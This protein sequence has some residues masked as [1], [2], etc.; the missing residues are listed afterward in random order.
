MC[1]IAGHWAHANGQADAEAVRRMMSA[2]G[3]RGPDGQ[4]LV[5]SGP[6]A[7]GHRRLSIIDLSGG[8]QPLTNEDGSVTVVFNGEIYNYRELAAGLRGKHELRTL[9]D[10]EVLVHL[11]EECGDDMVLELRG[12]FAFALW[13]S[14][15]RRLLAARDRLGKKPLLYADTGKA[16][17]FASELRAFEAAGAPL[18][19]IDRAALSEYL[20]LLYVPA[21][22]TIW[23]GVKKLPAGHLL[24]ADAGGV[25]VRRYWSPPVPGSR[26]MDRSDVVSMLEK[27]LADSVR[28]RLRSDV[29]VGVL[30]SGG[31]D[32]SVV[33]A[34][35]ARTFAGPLRTF[36]VGFGR[37]DDEL[38]IARA[39]AAHC[40]TEHR[41]IVLSQDVA[42]ATERALAGFSE[43]F[44]DSSAVPCS[45]VFREV[46][47]H[48]KVVLTGDGGDELF[49]GYGRYRTVARLP[50]VPGIGR[51]DMLP[52]WVPAHPRLQSLGRGAR[53][54]GARGAR[55]NRAMVEV[56]GPAARG[57]L[58]GGFEHAAPVVERVST[59]VEAALDADLCGYLPDD[60]LVKTD[61][62][63]MMWSVEARCPL[64]DQEL[65][66]AIVPLDSALKQNGTNGKLVL[67]DLAEKLVPAAVL[68]HPKRGFGSPVDQW[69]RGD[70]A[71]MLGDLV[72]SKSG[73]L[74]TLLD[75]R[76][77]DRVLA[78]VARGWGN[79]H[80]AWALLA[81]AAWASRSPA[82]AP[83]ARNG[84]VTRLP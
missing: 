4:G 69:L 52:S 37:A 3:H 12:M 10:T 26:R 63:S 73:P 27:L 41:E 8:A 24:T 18:G 67:R 82:T 9:S 77:V 16:L 79:A 34:L 28:L 19:S 1:G 21:P 81:L 76:A 64:L 29:P 6:V 80:Q 39:V 56:F 57:R 23:S 2:L 51:L 22:R 32:S 46:A 84:N 74:A 31:L 83:E 54:A 66:E 58:L 53:V 70:L 61:I 25:N 15:R 72:G 36:S 13:D 33:T 20:E 65:V 44:G 60:L 68:S 71:P 49:A 78:D 38:P 35:A 42:A 40:S 47:Q 5:V 14:R 55:R 45:E 17:W 59:D 75:F 11:Y 50:Y 43:P 7:L 30:L 62:T 48:V